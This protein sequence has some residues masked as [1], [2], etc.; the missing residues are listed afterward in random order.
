MA[1]I[2]NPQNGMS[3]PTARTAPLSARATAP[4]R[5]PADLWREMGGP[6]GIQP[7]ERIE[8]LES[9]LGALEERVAA[10]TLD[11][12]VAAGVVA[13]V[14]ERLGEHL[15]T[16]RLQ[17]QMR[18]AEAESERLSALAVSLSAAQDLDEVVQVVATATGAT[19]GALFLFDGWDALGQPEMITP[20]S[21]WPAEASAGLA[22]REWPVRGLPF[23]RY[24]LESPGDPLVF[25]NLDEM[26]RADPPRYALLRALGAR[27][28]SFLALRV[29]DQWVGLI[30]LAWAAPRSFRE[31]D[32]QRFRAIAA[33]SAV[34]VNGRLLYEQEH[35]RVSQLAMLARLEKALSKT[36]TDEDVVWAVLNHLGLNDAYTVSLA[37]LHL[38]SGGAPQMYEFAALWSGEQMRPI[39]AQP[40]PLNANALTAFWLDDPDALVCVADAF[41]DPRV[42][43]EL[44]EQ[45]AQDG[46]RAAV[47]M[48]LRSAG[49]W[50]GLFTITW[51]EARALTVE[52]RFL[53]P[54]VAES[55]GSA[56]AS[57]RA[58]LASQAAQQESERRARREAA[59]RQITSSLANAN[60]IDAVIRTAAEELERA[61]GPQLAARLVLDPEGAH[62]DRRGASAVHLDLRGPLA[63][64]DRS[65]LE[66]VALQVTQGLERVRLAQ[67]M[68][69]NLLAQQRLTL[70]LETVA[71]VSVA[72]STILERHLLLQEVVDLTKSR[73]NLY[74]AQIWALDELSGQ[75]QLAAGAGAI[76]RQMVSEGRSVPIERDPS[77]GSRS[78]PARAARQRTAVLAPD[79]ARDAGGASHR[80]LNETRSQLA[81]PLVVGDR[82]LGVLDV[83]SDRVGYFK[84]KDVRIYTTL[85]AQVAVALQN[86]N[87]YAEQAATVARLQELDHLKSAF[88][89][90]MSHELRTP[91]NSI[92]GF[93]DVI[94][95]GLDG[96][97][98][99]QMETDLGVVQ[100]NGRH[101]LELINDVLDMAKIEAGAMTIATEPVNVCDV[102]EEVVELSAPLA[103]AKA[104]NLRLATGPRATLTLVADPV[105]LRQVLINVVGNAIKFTE[106]GEIGISAER[107]GERVRI[108]VRDTGIGIPP[109][110]LETIFAAFSQVDTST[111]R[112]AGGTGL[113]LPISR[114]LIELHGGRMWAESPGLPGAGSRMII[115]LPVSGGTATD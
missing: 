77:V 24:W 107:L 48:P 82:L 11:L 100:K 81:V 45:A 72:A 83:Q 92:I 65:F 1:E 12:S 14:S 44:R 54:R 51:R 47:L 97:T 110:K 89:A 7:S 60:T 10:L 63:P 13:Q 29:S 59:L 113:G 39:A 114:N 28:A 112:K 80:L 90:N 95:E 88:L 101:L 42:P 37:H 33:Q 70:E 91:L 20:K 115:E 8:G 26:V 104:L 76:G 66:A 85:A 84:D 40:I 19:T 62:D 67:H 23:S 55:L 21:V 102:L 41:D 103:G 98:T 30:V 31:R 2:L 46:W 109:D 36:R 5:P 56:V 43:D 75:L 22:H 61:L 69:E 27:A 50:Q 71:Q 74:H 105:R 86:A 79:L 111:T 93:T 17:E 38:N 106:T 94:L 15:G 4:L 58:M 9:S 64:D 52:E 73:F 25:E 32:V 53:F 108:E 96:P 49:E 34:V 57:R 16:L 3:R 99:A 78:L 6:Q 35:R 87:L 18:Q 68:H